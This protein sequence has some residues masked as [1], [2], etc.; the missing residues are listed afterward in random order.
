MK[1]AIGSVVACVVFIA[2]YATAVALYASTG[3][4]RPSEVRA[5]QPAADGTS[6]TVDLV[7][8]QPINGVL[9]ANILVAP[10]PQLLAPHT[11]ILAQEF[12]VAVTSAVT[13]TKRTWPKGDVPGV[14]QVSM[15]ITGDPAEYPFD[16]Y[17]SRPITVELFR[18]QAQIPERAAVTFVDRLR[19]WKV[20]IE[21]AARKISDPVDPKSVSQDYRVLVQRSPSTAALAAIILFVLT[22]IAGMGLFV[23]VQTARNKRKFQPPMTTWYAAM[24][25]AI[26]PLR[27]ALPDSPPM[28]WWVDVTV[29]VWV[30]LILALSMLLYIFCWWRHLRPEIGTQHDGSRV[31]NTQSGGPPTNH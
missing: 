29:V 9:V 1:V 23:A 25:F 27:N 24:L 15:S 22:L 5:G 14:F 19:G 28:G 16:H 4:G 3:L 12:S 26:V 17:R 20:S 31:P 18:G 30:I 7:D 11:H 6:V 8:V 13:P 21:D 10:G 2:A